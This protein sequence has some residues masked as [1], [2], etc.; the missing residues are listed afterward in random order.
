MNRLLNWRLLPCYPVILLAL[1]GCTEVQVFS[2]LMK[3]ST[4]SCATEGT[5]KVGSPY[6]VDGVR[7]APMNSS[8]GYHEKGIAS[9]YGDDFHGLA[10]ANGECYNMYAYTA[11]HKTLPMPTVVRVTNLENNKSVIVK[12]NDRGP[13]VRGRLIDLSYAAAQSLDIVRMG[14][15]PVLVEAIGG[16]FNGPAGES[17]QLAATGGGEGETLAST[18]SPGTLEQNLPT[19]FDSKGAGVPPPVKPQSLPKPPA[20]PAPATLPLVNSRVFVQVGAF[21]DNSRAE[22]ALA[23]LK[24]I[25]ASAHTEQTTTASGA[26]LTRVRSGPYDNVEDAEAALGRLAGHFPDAKIVVEKK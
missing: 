10:T 19:A 17:A 21:G 20:G 15:A 24:G 13:F 11:A 3:R 25:D 26:S 7:Y 6:M 12:V 14:S 22:A 8:A 4:S 18:P 9:W 23:D 16:P 5:P 1:Q 2:H